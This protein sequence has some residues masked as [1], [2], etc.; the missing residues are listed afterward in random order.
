MK[1]PKSFNVGT[2]IVTF[3]I[4]VAAS[5]F[6]F[7][8][9]T[10]SVVSQD[11]TNAPNLGPSGKGTG[12]ATSS[13][14]SSDGLTVDKVVIGY[15]SVEDACSDFDLERSRA[16]Q[17]IELSRESS[18]LVAK[19]GPSYRPLFKVITQQKNQISYIQSPHLEAALAFEKSWLK[20]L[21]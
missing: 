13:W 4:G 16:D 15:R 14:V 20:T 19:F 1:R 8:P 11:G 12:M 21:W 17:V 10:F 9:R 18:R 5:V 6:V 2:A 3:V 7:P